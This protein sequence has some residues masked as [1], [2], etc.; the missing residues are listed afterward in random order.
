M[1]DN[2]K[3]LYEMTWEKWIT[4][5]P[6]T[7][8]RYARASRTK[9]GDPIQKLLD[10]HGSK[11]S[12]QAKEQSQKQSK[13]SPKRNVV[14]EDDPENDSLPIKQSDLTQI[15]NLSKS[16]TIALSESCHRIEKDNRKLRGRSTRLEKENRKL[17]DRTSGLEDD[18]NALEEEL[19]VQKEEFE[20]KISSIRRES[21][22]IKDQLEKRIKALEEKVDMDRQKVEELRRE[23]NE[24]RKKEQIF[25]EVKSILLQLADK[26]NDNAT[27]F[28]KA[29]ELQEVG[30]RIAASEVSS[31]S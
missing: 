25:D 12:K 18:V 3:H 9:P 23:I 31:S 2:F 30:K 27:F 26:N 20:K 22:D 6:S 1:A 11:R 4:L 19:V 24:L 29:L 21:Q 15:Y 28:Q 10:E 8:D 5:Q 16:L 13:T 14:S 7:Q 17:Q